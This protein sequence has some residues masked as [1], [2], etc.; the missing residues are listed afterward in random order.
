MSPSYDYEHD[1]PTTDCT[2]GQTFE[3]FESITA[4]RMKYCQCCGKEVH[5]LISAGGGLIFKG[6]GFYQTDYKGVKPEKT[7]G[8]K[9]TEHK[10]ADPS[11][12]VEPKTYPKKES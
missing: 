12:T 5:R 2:K 9:P 10:A 8:S 4:E 6:T 3:V 1:A 7:V 11:K